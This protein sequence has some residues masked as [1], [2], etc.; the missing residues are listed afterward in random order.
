[1]AK[2]GKMKEAA[3][4]FSE[5]VKLNPRDQEAWHNLGTARQR[6]GDLR[7]A[8]EAWE[9]QAALD[10]Q[11]KN[12]K[13]L[14][15]LGWIYYELKDF[16]KAEFHTRQAL[17]IHPEDVWLQANYALILLVLVR[18]ERAREHYQKAVAV[19]SDAKE[20]EARTLG[21]LK[22]AIEEAQKGGAAIAGARELFGFLQETI[23][24]RE[25]FWKR[26]DAYRKKYFPSRK[27]KLP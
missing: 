10:P 27:G 15:N 20:L 1:L 18:P 9:A 14:G 26:R 11:K 16:P 4:S 6:M 2:A 5:A 8:A 21:D 12:D 7:G 22:A 25:R 19:A 13:V 3:E 23:Q 24:D 17:E